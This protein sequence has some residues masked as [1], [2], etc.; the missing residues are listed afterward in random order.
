MNLS[1]FADA[2]Q[3][4]AKKEI[5][6]YG[7]LM[8]NAIELMANGEFGKAAAYHQNI[9]LSLNSLQAMKNTKE[10][11]EEIDLKINQIKGDKDSMEMLRRNYF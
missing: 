11:Y 2:D 5:D 8:K 9:A 7:Y 4:Q 3:E 10:T 6:C 1:L